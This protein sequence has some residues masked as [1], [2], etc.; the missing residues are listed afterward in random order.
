MDSLMRDTLRPVLQPLSGGHPGQFLFPALGG[1]GSTMIVNGNVVGLDSL[2]QLI[3][4]EVTAAMTQNHRAG[5]TRA[6]A[7]I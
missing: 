2:R 6:R 4:G 3:R 1:S 7:G 5:T